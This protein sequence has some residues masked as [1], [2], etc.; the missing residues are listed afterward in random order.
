MKAISDYSRDTDDE[1]DDVGSEAVK[2]LTGNASFTV[3]TELNKVNVAQTDFHGKKAAAG[4]G[5]PA[6]V[7]AKN[8]ARKVLID[9]LHALAL[10]VNI[11]ANGNETKL[12]S[13]GLRLTKVATNEAL[14]QP[15]GLVVKQG[16][17]S[18]TISIKVNV[19]GAADHGTLF[20]YSPVSNPE[21]N[22]NEWKMQ[23]ANGHSI[24]ING[25]VRGTE[26]NISAAYK[27]KDGTV[28]AWCPA[29][30]FMVV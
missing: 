12:K 13:T 22:P 25:L 18:G 20:A 5:G 21:T 11:Q 17:A 3:T 19:P 4:T 24:N 15:T 30:K 16:A 6:A 27:G 7:S 2:N 26:Y 14:P 1:L 8:D 9:A 28:L 23:H 10:V 29:I